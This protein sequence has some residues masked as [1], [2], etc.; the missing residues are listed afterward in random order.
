MHRTAPWLA[1]PFRPFYLLGAGYAV[2]LMAVAGLGFAGVPPR[3]IFPLAWHGHEMVFGFAMAIV[4]GTLLTALPTWA[5]TAPMHGARL[6]LLAGLWLLGRAG[7]VVS[8]VQPAVP[9]FAVAAADAALPLAMMV[10]LAPQLARLPQ[11]RWRMVLVVLAAFAAAN[12]GWHAAFAAGD[13]AGASRALRAALW[14]MVMLYTLAGGLFTPVFTANVLAERGL[15]ALAPRRWP[16]EAATVLLTLAAAL[17]DL[18]LA[19]PR[20]PAGAL[21]MAAA[22]AQAWRLARWRGWQTRTDPLVWA[23]HAGFAWLVVALVF[24]GA[25]H[26]GWIE[27]RASW[28]HAFTAG[29]LG[30]MMLGLMT[31]VA[32]R[33][34]GRA[35]A[36]PRWLPL[37]LLAVSAATVLRLGAP[38][39]GTAAWTAAA[40]LWALAMAAWWLRFAGPLLRPSLP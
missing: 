31:R 37:A 7:G 2:L 25:T 10:L 14:V 36:A 35:A 18:A 19:A 38:W 6:A 39:L 28:Q 30:S 22:I 26:F 24:A 21:A 8:S 29:A 34:T 27:A 33:H 20:P 5:G 1:A 11:R 17:A 16:L 40:L 12:V 23:M 4:A 13:S 15:P 9:W 3:A 32:L